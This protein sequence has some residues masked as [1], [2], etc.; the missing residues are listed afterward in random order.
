MRDCTCTTA[1]ML[2]SV[3]GLLCMAACTCALVM[4]LCSPSRHSEYLKQEC[5]LRDM[6]RGVGL[7]ALCLWSVV[8]VLTPTKRCSQTLVFGRQREL[9]GSFQRA[10][11]QHTKEA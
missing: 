5:A 11:G 9:C 2:C 4:I 7:K 3:A 6:V 1:A 10:H 8:S